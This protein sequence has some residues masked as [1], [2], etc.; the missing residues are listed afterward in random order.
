M[1]DQINAPGRM[2]VDLDEF[3]KYQISNYGEFVNARTDRE[4][5]PSMTKQGHAKVTLLS[6]EG[7]QMTRGVAPIIARAFNDPPYKLHFNTII[8]LDGDFMNCVAW[9]LMWRPR[10]F[11]I[12][13]HKQFNYE[14]FYSQTHLIELD[15]GEEYHSVQEACMRNGL[16]YHD[17]IKSFVEKTFVPFTW[18]EFRLVSEMH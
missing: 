11:A 12:Q 15:S 18:Q 5:V 9:N 16:Y 6:P 7:K 13:Y 3:P 1:L 8:H 10:W 2:W 17:V 4:V 14:N